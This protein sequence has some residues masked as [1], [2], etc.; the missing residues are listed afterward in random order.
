[1]NYDQVIAKPGLW[2]GIWS[3]MFIESTFM[4]YG[5]GPGRIIGITLKPSTLKRWALSLHIY[6]QIMKDVTEMRET[7]RKTTVT[8]HKEEMPSR[9]QSDGVDRAKL[10][11]RLST[12]IDPLQPDSHPPGLINIVNGRLSP[13]NVN[14]DVSVRIGT[15]QMNDYQL[16]W[17]ESFNKPL[18]KQVV[19]M[20]VSQRQ[21]KIRQVAVY[22]T[23]LIYSRVLGLQ[24]VRDINLKDILLYE[25]AT[26]G[27]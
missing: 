22:D 14:V 2:N 23:S 6:S 15:D 26:V 12:C 21:L 27:T 17:P 5:H 8:E 20:P 11:D 1:M 3:D 24:N 7:R 18:T 19:V 25:L 16:L 13:D 4:H 10:K 9:I